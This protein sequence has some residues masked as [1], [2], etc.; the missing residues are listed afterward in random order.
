MDGKSVNS[1]NLSLALLR[2]NEALN[3]LEDVWI[4]PD[5]LTDKEL[6]VVKNSWRNILN[7][8]KKITPVFNRIV[9]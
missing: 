5:G 6:E 3:Y 8:H 7:V 1:V 2:M 4:S 9:K